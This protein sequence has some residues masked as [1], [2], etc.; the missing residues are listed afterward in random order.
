[1]NIDSDGFEGA[2]AAPFSLVRAL[3]T[4]LIGQSSTV[5]ESPL[6]ILALRLASLIDEGVRVPE[7]SREFRQCITELKALSAGA[8]KDD[9]LNEL[10][11]KRERRRSG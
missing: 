5:A 3:K 4:E 2:P 10:Q 8:W 6:A 11:A 1:M 7:C 9:A